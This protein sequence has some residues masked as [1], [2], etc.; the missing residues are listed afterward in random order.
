MEAKADLTQL[1]SKSRC[2]LARLSALLPSRLEA[3]EGGERALDLVAHE[4]AADEDDTRAVVLVRPLVQVPR[5]LLARLR[6]AQPVHRVDGGDHPLEPEVVLH[7]RLRDERVE[8]R[9]RVG[10]AGGLDDHAPELRDL[11]ALA[12][13]EEVAQLVGEVA[14]QRAADAA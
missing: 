2:R 14:A 11:A 10:H 3:V 5:W 4:A 9:G 7:H 6:R 8:D 13:A 1:P 12:P